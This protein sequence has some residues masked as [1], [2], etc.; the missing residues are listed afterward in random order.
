MSS[1]NAVHQESDERP[2]EVLFQNFCLQLDPFV[3]ENKVVCEHVLPSCRG[4]M[5][6]DVHIDGMELTCWPRA[7]GV[8]RQ[9]A[10]AL[11][12]SFPPALIHNPLPWVDYVGRPRYCTKMDWHLRAL[13]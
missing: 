10:V 13:P 5:P 8:L 11:W 12:S 2:V 1:A 7:L 4:A 3:F 6:Y 9:G